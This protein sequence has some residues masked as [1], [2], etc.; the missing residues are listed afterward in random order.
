MLRSNQQ[1]VQRAP[2]G[3]GQPQERRRAAVLLTHG[4]GAVGQKSVL[5]ADAAGLL[6]LQQ[7]RAGALAAAER[8]AC[9]WPQAALAGWQPCLCIVAVPDVTRCQPL[10]PVLAHFVFEVGALYART[11]PR[12]LTGSS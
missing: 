7:L 6:L 3:Q 11:Q 5:Q 2:G 8:T 9:P 1:E 4:A 10:P 12:V